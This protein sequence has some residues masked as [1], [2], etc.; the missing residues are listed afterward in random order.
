VFAPQ[1]N[2]GVNFDGHRIGETKMP[3]ID[4]DDVA[5][6][7]SL[8]YNATATTM[9]GMPTLKISGKAFAGVDKGAM[10]FKLTGADHAKALKLKG[11]KLFDPMGGRPMKE[12]VQ[13]PAAHSKHWLKFAESALKYVKKKS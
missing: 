7:M 5:E 6:Q 11:A 4:Y 3:K 2:C 13:V 1:F 8:K 9:F 10:M 12:W